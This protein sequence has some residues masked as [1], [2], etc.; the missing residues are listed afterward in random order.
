M[1]KGLRYSISIILLGAIQIFASGQIDPV[2]NVKNR[3][4]NKA[5]QYENAG[6]FHKAID[7]FK[8]IVNESPGFV[9]GYLHLGICYLNL[10]N[11]A[12][13]AVVYLEKGFA[14]LGPEDSF[15]DLGIDLQLT[16]AKSY[17]VIMQTD[18][19]LDVYEYIQKNVD[20]S[21]TELFEMIEKEK[22]MCENAKIFL[23]NPID[24]TITNLGEKINSKYDDHSPL[25]SVFEDL[26]IFT[27]RREDIKL[28]K[29]EDGQYPEKIYSAQFDGEWENA[30]SL[31]HFFKNP[32]HESALSLSADGNELFI[33]RNDDEGKS[34]YVSRK[35]D[36][37]WQ[38]P[39]KL[40]YPINTLADETHA[41]LSADKS[42]LFFVSNREGGYGGTDIYMVKK[43]TDGSWGQVHNLG[44]VVN[45]KYDEETAMIHPDGTTLYFASEGHNSMGRLDVFF[46]Q[47]RADSTWEAP[48]NLGY[49]I[50]TPDDDFFFIP[51]LDKS[52]AYY[53]S[54]RFND[55]YGGSDIYKVEFDDAFEGELAIIEGEVNDKK[56]LEEGSLRIMVTRQSDNELV[57]DYRPNQESGKY[58]MFLETG[59]EYNIQEKQ[60]E[61]DLRASVID[62]TPQMAYK[63]TE[64]PVYSFE[65]IRMEPPL[66]QMIAG[67]D[68]VQESK[69]IEEQIILEMQNVKNVD[70][71]TVQILALKRRP[72]FAFIYFKGLNKD[73]IQS[74]KC[75][76]GYT[77]YV[78]GVYNNKEESIKAR[79]ELLKLGRFSDSF[80]RP[81]SD[82]EILKLN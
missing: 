37:E 31:T 77:R 68:F 51:T 46:T 41:S 42:T 62:V 82:I 57:G 10:N 14:Q 21:N 30:S 5:I 71:Y 28:A 16:L 76:D 43:N 81:I 39:E 35:V 64:A 56:V 69:Q 15:S 9:E 73:D 55:N 19:A 48:V 8:E 50:N 53:A 4:V 49:P 3:D 65:E 24:I 17:Q 22:D 23:Q 59:Q 40:P 25:V 33:Y 13:T 63:E 61:K 38:E 67:K 44:P 11:S 6:D 74:Y 2:N 32:E 75:S 45:T 7:A 12:D 29:H 20:S 60:G 47:M 52:K 72:V 54:A 78:Y 1:Y 80:V 34:I 66:V 70:Y 27:S 58:L 36:G 18:K 26:V 79:T